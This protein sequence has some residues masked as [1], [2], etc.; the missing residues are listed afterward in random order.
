MMTLSRMGGRIGVE[1]TGMDIRTMSDADFNAIYQAW[2]EASVL[3]IRDQKLEIADWLAFCG[4]FG[5]LKPHI[6]RARGHPEFPN[7][8]L[9]DNKAGPGQPASERLRQGGAVWHSDLG[10]EKETAKATALHAIHLPSSGGD[11]LFKSMYATYDALPDPLKRRIEGRKALFNYGGRTR[12]NLALLDKSEHDRPAAMHDLVR[13]H[14]ETGRKALYVS[15]NQILGIA[16]M[17]EEDSNAL[18]DE[19]LPYAMETEV[20]YRHRW[21]PGD[22][23]VWD[24]RCLLHRATGDYPPEER[25][26][27]WRTTIM[28]NDWD[29]AQDQAASA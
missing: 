7:L 5:K 24:N 13:V 6:N 26:L 15:P 3:V 25:R 8:M 4:R 28:R 16:G 18:L 19:L 27:H 2:L 20:D 23:V 29:G 12:K 22:V 1:V 9:L 14:P 10:Y 11:T 17:S 21:K